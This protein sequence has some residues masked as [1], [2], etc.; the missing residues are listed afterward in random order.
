MEKMTHD[1]IKRLY[2]L[3]LLIRRFDEEAIRLYSKGKLVGSVHPYVGEEAIAAGIGKFIRQDDYFVSTHRGHGHAIAKGVPV[4]RMMAELMGKATGCC[5]GKGGS[6]HIA[7]IKRGLAGSNGIVGAGMPIA[8]GLGLAAQV[9]KTDQVAVCFFGDGA[10]NE[11]TF[12]ESLNLASVWHL[13]VIFVCENNLYAVSVS[14]K[15]HSVVEN[16]ADR[17]IGYGIPGVVVDGMDVMSVMDAAEEAVRR[18]RNGEGPTLIEAKTFRYLG[19]S[20]GDP[21][22]GTYRTKEEVDEWKKRD[23][24]QKL[25]KDGELTLEEI[26]EIEQHVKEILRAAVEF[27]DN[28]PLPEISTALTDVYA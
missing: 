26:S 4:D 8:V 10:S 20:R 5:H 19:H 18:A 24:L 17:A 25:A 1:E 14:K 16:I 6:M 15:K 3:M 9:K 2:E 7:D 27:A 28:S 11:G 21:P 23:C 12:H 13:P 22:Y